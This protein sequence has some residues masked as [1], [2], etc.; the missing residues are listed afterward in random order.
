MADPV[1]THLS[2]E[3][4]ATEYSVFE[5]D[6]VLTEAQ[7]NTLSRYFDDQDR[8]TRVE[9]LGV[10]IVGGLNVVRAAN[11]VVV[12][13]GVGITT[14]G[15]L[16]LLGADTTYD[17]I[18]PYDETA[19]VYKPFYDGSK[20]MTLFELVK[21]GESD[22]RKQ[23]MNTLPGNLADYAVIFYMESYE[24]DHDLCSGTDCD[25]LGLSAV[26]T[27]RLLL[28]GK[29]DALKLLKSL[30]TASAAAAQLTYIAADRIK[31]NASIDSTGK[32]ATAYLGTCTNI[33]N[34]LLQTLNSLN[35]LLPGLVV[36]QF[37]S[38]PIGGWI[39]KLNSLNTQFAN[40]SNAAKPSIQYYYS[41][42]KDIAETW[43]DLRTQLFANDSVLCPDL[44]AFPKHLLLGSLSAPQE[45][46]TSLYPSPL[47]SDSRIAREHV[48]FLVSK[49]H[50]MFNTVTLPVAVVPMPVPVPAPGSPANPIR[51]TPSRDEHISIEERAIPFYYVDSGS[52]HIQPFWSYELSANQSAER[53]TAYRW[54]DYAGKA[55]P[56]FFA[57]QIG[58]NDFFRIE[59]HQGLNVTTALNSLKTLIEAHNLP[60]IVRAVLLH[61]DKKKIVIRPPRYR[62]LHRIH[63][64]LRK[65]VSAQLDYG[66]AFSDKFSKDLIAAAGKTIPANVGGKAIT[67]YAT[68]QNS[69][70]V[71]AVNKASPAVSQKKYSSYRQSMGSQSGNWKADYKEAV[72]AAGNYKREVGDV[73]RTD[74]STP[75]DTM[76][77][78]NQSAWLNWLDIIIDKHEDREDDKLLLPAFFKQHPGISHC[79]GVAR[80]GTFVLVYDD[81]ANI[82]ADFMLPYYAP[83]LG[84]AEPDDEPD[85]PWPDF[86]LPD[87]IL[88]KGIKLIEPPDIRWGKDLAD[89]ADKLKGEWKMDLDIQTNYMDFFTHN[90]ETMGDIFS[91]FNIGNVTY[92]GNFGDVNV[93]PNTGDSMMDSLL[94]LITNGRKQVEQ[95]M[96]ILAKENLPEIE[97]GQAE[98]VL[99]DLQATLATNINIATGYMVNAGLD[100]GVGQKGSAAV[101][102]I[103]DGM[104][105]ITNDK[106]RSQLKSGLNKAI[107][108]APTGQ[109]GQLNI[110]MNIGG[111]GF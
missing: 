61:N 21:E 96:A 5:P 33:H 74:F 8:L 34:K 79:G 54:A 104:R 31:L 28:V 4:L 45:L 20:M 65:E 109:R 56:D 98:K 83:E 9:L 51:I 44:M 30:T 12:G 80:G 66:K 18:K 62:D 36:E 13:K 27:P 91:K 75:F 89:L 1:Q 105:T 10:G 76:V 14:D 73:L 17:C 23:A 38:N 32:L 53:T 29:A 85:L 50:V 106:A 88:D 92:P 35:T 99:D 40:P 102:I 58:R 78:S 67:T 41:F 86:R 70:V 72:D 64:M 81:S 16:M 77:V 57:T 42:L 110:M 3:N 68:E 48:R 108:N 82:V 71:N 63:Y 2:L 24:Q 39:A 15:D 87:D 69:K 6:Q 7:L 26:N 97:R 111:F 93:L 103:G 47:T 107:G 84:E 37:G 11:K 19:P 43:D 46:R 22:V 55:A 95:V 49:L 100:I 60:F 25:N 59:G 52:F 101:T 90:I 94:G